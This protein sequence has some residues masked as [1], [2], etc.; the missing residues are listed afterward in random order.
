MNKYNDGENIMENAR[1]LEQLQQAIYD[2]DEAK[3]V[4]AALGLLDFKMDPMS[5][6]KQGITPAMDKIGLAFSSGDAFLPELILAGDAARGALDQI[7]PRLSPDDLEKA[8]KGTV[9]IGTIF[10]DNHDIGKNI[11]SALL[12]AYGMKVIDLGI[13]VPVRDFIEAAIK[14]KADIIA[15]SSLITTSL[16]Y[17]REVIRNLKDRGIRDKFFVIV[18]GGPVTPEWVVEIGADGYGR[19]AT[20]AAVLCTQLLTGLAQGVVPPVPN[21]IIIGALTHG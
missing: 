15:I 17:H 19:D 14:E 18:G 10:G 16:P 20:N 8:V 5:I 9:V 1:L 3:S 21:P 2:G 12:M 6:I 11:V 13:N 7:I 4:E